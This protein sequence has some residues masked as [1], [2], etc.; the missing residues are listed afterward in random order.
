MKYRNTLVVLAATLLL[1]TAGLASA[2]SNDESAAKAEEAKLQARLEAEYE[3]AM[4]AAERQRRAAEASVE[5]AREQ[6]QL[7]SEQKEL[8][9]M[10][11]EEA[12]ARYEA[13]M[14]KMH[15]ELNH[16]HRQLQ[17]TT[18]EIARVNRE[19]ARAQATRHSEKHFVIRTSERPVI[20]VILGG[21][22]TRGV[23]VLGVSPDGPSEKAGIKKGDLIVAVGGRELTDINDKGDTR[24][25]LRIAMRDIEAD[26][27]LVISVEREKKTIDLTVVPEIREPMSWQSVTRFP[28][29][30]RAPHSPNAPRAPT[31][32]DKVISIERIVVPEIDT[33]EM[34]EQIEQMRV[35]IEK[36]RVLREAGRVEPGDGEWEIE[37]HE[38]SELGTFALQGANVWYGLPMAQGLKLAEIDPGLGEYFKTD[39][40]VLV[41]K[42]RT[43]NDLQLKSGDVILQ[44]GD[45]EVNSPAEFM[46]ALRGFNSGDELVMNIKRN[47][48]DRTLKTVMPEDRSSFSLPGNDETHTFTITSS[49]D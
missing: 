10:Q 13:E 38:L 37:L 19:V 23:E 22:D 21:A 17:E 8:S 31:A 40:G 25:G 33:V 35:E 6:L 20:G 7:A 15:E 32:P 44:V 27:P 11:S 36:R 14:S 1:G 29:A 5:K 3:N 18:R 43:D 42:A 46:R 30:P 34:T 9:A 39:R 26:E 16:T 28:T 45:S 24:E 4:S 48:K 47:R 49:S 2:S 41:L 12:R